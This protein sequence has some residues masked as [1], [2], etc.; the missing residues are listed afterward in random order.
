[1][2]ME[3]ELFEVQWPPKFIILLLLQ[4]VGPAESRRAH[5]S[6]PRLIVFTPLLVSPFTSR[7]TPRQ[8]A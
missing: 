5:C 1:M 6:L 3:M 8:T 4:S 2:G 7:G